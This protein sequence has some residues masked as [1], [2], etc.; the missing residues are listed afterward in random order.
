MAQWNVSK[1]CGD[2]PIKQNILKYAIGLI[3]L[4]KSCVDVFLNPNPFGH[5]N[6]VGALSDLIFDWN[7]YAFFLSYKHF[8]H[9]H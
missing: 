4:S 5:P 1:G 8:D 9:K 7:L 3:Y 2:K 6:R